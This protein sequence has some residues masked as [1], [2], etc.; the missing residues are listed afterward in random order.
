MQ[1][2]IDKDAIPYQR[3]P[4]IVENVDLV[5]IEIAEAFR[6]MISAQDRLNHA[7]GGGGV[8]DSSYYHHI[9]D[10]NINDYDLPGHAEQSLKRITKNAWKYI[11]DQTGL[12][13]YM[14]DKRKNEIY[15]QIE[16]GSLP[17]L[18][19]ENIQGTLM[20]LAGKM[21]GL[22]EES[23]REVFDWLR[24]LN[25]YGVGSLKTNKRFTVG[26]RAIVGW[27]VENSY[28]GVFR[29]QYRSEGKFLSMGNVFSLLDGK[30]ILKNPH[31]LVTRC[32]VAMISGKFTFEDDYFQFKFYRNG[33]T[34]IKFKRL[35]LLK[36]LNQI[37]GGE[38]LPDKDIHTKREASK[39]SMAIV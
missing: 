22:L 12:N 8:A 20:G 31:D 3:I 38:G 2:E 21:N 30:G 33:N 39:T 15:Q 11:L 16:N 10:H 32:K 26:K 27:S 35:D 5:K 34:H 25:D 14:T 19:A 1:N 9:F 4:A 17:P 18:T 36:K 7:L 6:L 24:P 23:I 28:N 29:F 37:S 13:Q